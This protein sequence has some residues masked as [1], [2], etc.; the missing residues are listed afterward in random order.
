MSRGKHHGEQ[1]F[2]LNIASIIDCFTVLITYLL[3]S[4]SFISLGILEVSIEGPPMAQP[5]PP[6]PEPT[7][8]L[9]VLLGDNGSLT[10]KASGK[11]RASFDIP[12]KAGKPDFDG[13]DAQLKESK[14]RWPTVDSI[15]LSATDGSVYQDLVRT[16]EVI[17]KEIPSVIIGDQEVE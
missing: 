10:L 8:N 7:V 16:V 4:A 1:D 2:E 17:K 11:E 15:K 9:S 5:N 12:A 6:P 3:V 13:L 14:I